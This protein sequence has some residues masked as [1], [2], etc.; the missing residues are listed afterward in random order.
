MPPANR[1]NRGDDAF[2]SQRTFLPYAAKPSKKRTRYYVDSFNAYEEE[3][4]RKPKRVA[5]KI[6]H[7]GRRFDISRAVGKVGVLVFQLGSQ[8]S[9]I[10]CSLRHRQIQ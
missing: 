3:D 8:I 4:L 7:T 6:R 5:T 1:M 9:T 2:P 10:S